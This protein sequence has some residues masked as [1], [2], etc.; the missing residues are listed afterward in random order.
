MKNIL[1]YTDGSAVVTGKNK[2]NGGFGT[3][4]PDLNGE[5]TAFSL[6]YKH[7]KTGRVEILALMYA[8]KALPLK[9]KEVINLIVYA[10]SE[11]VIKSFTEGRLEN[12]QNN[13]WKTKPFRGKVEDIKNKE[14]WLEVL[15]Q[16]DKRPFL[17]LTF[18][19]IR[20]HQVEKEK[21]PIK[22][23]KL[24]KDPHIRGNMI[25]DKLADYKRH[26]VLLD[27]DFVIVKN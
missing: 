11:Y 27:K 3:Y 19:H 22:K 6:G 20:S 24:L 13:G 21:D 4:F 15:R 7:T 18:N 2:G 5:K 8:I 9:S 12:W 25:A 26:K 17:K 1:V 14:L 10:D 16:I 23:A